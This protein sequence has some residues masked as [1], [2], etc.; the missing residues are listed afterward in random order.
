LPSAFRAAEVAHRD[1]LGEIFRPTVL[2]TSRSLPQSCRVSAQLAA[3]RTS[4]QSAVVLV[5]TSIFTASEQNN[6]GDRPHQ[7]HRQLV[8][9]CERQ[10]G[11]RR[12]GVGVRRAAFLGWSSESG[13]PPRHR[14]ITELPPT[15][16][17][18][19]IGGL[20]PIALRE[21]AS[22][23]HLGNTERTCG[24]AATAERRAGAE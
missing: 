6:P 2:E 17:A 11:E 10:A 15:S 16:P 3:Q 7:G 8:H 13:V 22:M 23:H 18:L 20:G 12:A 1:W 24:G 14:S 19:I 21:V 5:E 4:T 9:V